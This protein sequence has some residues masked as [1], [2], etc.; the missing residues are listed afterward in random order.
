MCVIIFLKLYQGQHV[1]CIII[2]FNSLALTP[3]LFLT[4]RRFFY[5]PFVVISYKQ[6]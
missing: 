6:L 3:Y 5:T 4:L 2:I 1:P